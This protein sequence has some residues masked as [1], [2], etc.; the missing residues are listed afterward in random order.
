MQVTLF[1]PHDLPLKTS[2]CPGVQLALLSLSSLSVI[3]RQS[4]QSLQ[5]L[6]LLVTHTWPVCSKS[7]ASVSACQQP[8]YISF[9][10]LTIREQDV[11][12][13]CQMF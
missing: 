13:Y 4:L 2:L 7:S 8:S 3:L 1:V 12:Q 10:M 9:Y 6:M 5:D 11:H